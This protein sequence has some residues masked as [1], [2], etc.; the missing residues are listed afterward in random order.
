MKIVVVGGGVSGAHAALTLLER[1][2]SVELWDVGREEDPFPEKGT[3]FHDLKK[4]LDDPVAY[5]LGADL[6]TL[7]PPASEELLRYPPSRNFLASR[8]DTLWGFQSN[9]F[10]PFGSYNK[11]GLA[12]GW[13]ANALAFDENDLADWPISFADMEAAYKTVYSRIPVAGPVDDELASWLPGVHP[14]QPPVQLTAA[15]KGFLRACHNKKHVL[16]RL[17]IHI[18]KAR[19]AVVTDRER[20][21]ACDYCDRCLWGCPRGSIYNPVLSTLRACNAYKTFRYVPGRHVL[22][23]LSSD[24]RITGIRYMDTETRQ[25]QQEPCDNVFLAAGALASGS[26]FLRTLKGERPGIS[27]ETEGLMD[28]SVVK[29]PFVALRNIGRTPEAR[30]FQFNRLIMGI[31][32]A[33]GDGKWPRYLH[34]ELLHLTSL[35]Y[36]P[37]IESMPLGSRLS[38]KLFFTLKSALGTVSL[39]FPDKITAGNRQ[40]L[41]DNGDPCEK[42]LLN[43][44]ETDE[45]QRYIQQ[46]VRSVHAAL[47]RL[48]CIPRGIIQSPPGGGIHYAGTIPMGNGPKRCNPLGKSNLFSNLYI[49]DGAAFPSLPSKSITMSLA[50]HATRVATHAKL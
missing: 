1:N 44:R 2:F 41:A 46:S 3:T 17:G 7:I 9:N 39:F 13:G 28:T 42:T 47:W 49:A 16:S 27:P 11:G 45:R 32:D 48:G 5:F 43:Y 33:N 10:F 38:K 35:L 37:L 29:L 23:L 8:E 20:E 50:A 19:L 26:I 4:S 36:H 6:S 21:D 24:N 22:S 34:G 25:V 30:S 40:V 18:G 15:D 31:I 12:N 14:S